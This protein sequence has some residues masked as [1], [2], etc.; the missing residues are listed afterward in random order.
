MYEEYSYDNEEDE[1]YDQPPP[2]YRG[3]RRGPPPGDSRRSRVHA[4]SREGPSPRGGPARAVLRR[5][6]RGRS[7]AVDGRPHE[8]HGD[9]QLPDEGAGGG[10]SLRAV[11]VALAAAAR[12]FAEA[13]LFFI[14]PDV[15]LTAI[16]IRAPRRGHHFVERGRGQLQFFFCAER[17]RGYRG[18]E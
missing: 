1:E 13:T 18:R 6:V 2:S 17:A 15:L 14:V 16:T 10:R 7:A 9:T 8:L 11:G 3:R 4:R 5:C 12:G